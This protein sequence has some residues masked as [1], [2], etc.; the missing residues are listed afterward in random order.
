MG[1]GNEVADK[2]SRTEDFDDWGAF[3]EL[4]QCID[5]KWGPHSIDRFADE[6]NCKI[7]V[8]NSKFWSSASGRVDKG[9]FMLKWN[10]FKK[11]NFTNFNNKFYIS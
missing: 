3:R 8:F 7:R 5:S 9:N 10:F 2:L 6:F 4:F 11:V 1:A